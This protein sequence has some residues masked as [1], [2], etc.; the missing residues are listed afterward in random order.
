[1]ATITSAASGN[2]SDTAT[3]VGGVV[4]TSVDDVIITSTHI[5]TA[6]VDITVLTITSNANGQ[7]LVNSA[8]NITCTASGGIT[9]NSSNASTQTTFV[10]ITA[11]SPNIV[12]I[13]SNV[14]MESIV[15]AGTTNPRAAIVMNGTA[16]TNITGNVTTNVTQLDGQILVGSAIFVNVTNTVIN[17]I[18]NLTGGLQASFLKHGIGLNNIS[19]LNTTI[20]ITGNCTARLGSAVSGFGTNYQ[21][22]IT[23]IGTIT[24][25]SSRSALIGALTNLRVFAGGMIVN[26]ANL[27][28]ISGPFIS[29]LSTIPTQW[30]FQTEN[31]LVDKTLYDTTS[32]PSLPATSD[33]RNLTTYANGT[34][35]GTLAVPSPSNVASGVP[36]DNTVGTAALTPAD[37]WDYLTSGATAGSMGERVAAIPTNPASVQSTGAQIASFNT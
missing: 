26:T 11:S 4:P 9:V 20:T 27:A 33:V 15:V 5:V 6:D 22:T 19:G 2:W 30:L 18:G 31:A 10:N 8:R 16:T 7:L 1:M 32:L 17:I 25:S 24:G 14:T 28:A 29:L 12:N 3:W 23:A 21:G 34:L 37:F 13:T 35:T 36:T